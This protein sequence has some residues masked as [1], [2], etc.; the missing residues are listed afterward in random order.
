MTAVRDTLR[1]QLSLDVN[2]CEITFDGSPPANC[3]PVFYGV[4]Y[5]QWSA[6]RNESLDERLGVN[7]TVTYKLEATPWDRIGQE[8]IVKARKGLEAL[9]GQVRAT[10]IVNDIAVIVAA[11]AIIDAN[12]GG[13]GFEEPLRFRDGGRPT[14]QGGKWFKA[15]NVQIAGLSQTLQFRDARRVQKIEEAT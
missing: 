6:S 10:L 7:V 8:I 1:S 2:T 12:Q 3:P 4:H 9:C 5:G 14:P 11:N 13:N 15:R